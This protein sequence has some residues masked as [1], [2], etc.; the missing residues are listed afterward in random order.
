[1]YLLSAIAAT[2]SNSVVTIDVSLVKPEC[3]FLVLRFVVKRY[4]GVVGD[5]AGVVGRCRFA[6]GRAC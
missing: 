3:C 6:V 5:L 4:S 1:M 2:G